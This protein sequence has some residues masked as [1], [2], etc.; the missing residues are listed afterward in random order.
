MAQALETQTKYGTIPLNKSLGID[1][2]DSQPKQKTYKELERENQKLLERI[3]SLKQQLEWF[4]R[5]TFGRKSEKR[6]N[7]D[8]PAQLGLFDNSAEPPSEQLESAQQE[9]P[10]TKKNQRR[11][12]RKGAAQ[13]TGLRFDESIPRRVIEILPDELKGPE[14][15]E[16][17][18]IDTRIERYL[19]QTQ[20]CHEIIEYHRP[21]IK[22]IRKGNMKTTPA[23]D[24]VFGN[25]FVDVSFAAGMLV[26]KFAYHMPLYRQHQRL[27]NAGIYIA[28]STLTNVSER[29]IS[30]LEP[31]FQAQLYSCMQSDVLA[32]DETP[33][34]AGRNKA[35]KKMKQ[36][37]FWPIYG[38]KDEICFVYTPDRGMANVENIIGNNYQGVLLTDG[39]SAYEK[40]AAAR[41]HITHAQCW[42]HTRRM[43]ERALGSD[44]AAE[45]ALA[46]IGKLYK[47]EESI[48]EKGLS[49]ADKLK[50][51]RDHSMPVLREFWQW[52]EKQL[53]SDKFEPRH[54]LIK[55]VNY[56]YQRI[57]PLEVFLADPDVPIDTNHLER[58]L[59]P[60]PMGRKAWLFCWSELGAE[61]VG[62]IQSLIS[63]CRIHGINPY[64]Y[65]VD[66]LQR[67]NIHPNKRVEELTPRRWKELF[68]DNPMC[69]PIES[70]TKGPT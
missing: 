24:S 34:K 59:R 6:I 33:V 29:A 44:P 68:A 8:P 3:D 69:S 16:Y 63:T 54:P 55:A 51:R 60:I 22:H 36:A 21:V 67:V 13:D 70:A 41:P 47:I 40:F 49:G 42:A 5:Q 15:D 35:K 64:T 62:I 38:D 30:L 4:S 25:S 12:N 48:R 28:R 46:Y 14:A 2:L 61:H 1:A 53:N 45:Q 20:V 58:G 65:L 27:D 18:I 52:C 17:Q 43:F 32:M 11:K 39:Y 10:E 57:H 23:P 31:I 19:A 50:T 9:Q 7:I 66:V 56:A 26:D 37:Y